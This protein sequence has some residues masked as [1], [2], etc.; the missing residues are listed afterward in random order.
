MKRDT[1]CFAVSCLRGRSADRLDPSSDTWRLLQSALLLMLVFFH[2]SPCLLPLSLTPAPIDKRFICVA[3]VSLALSIAFFFS[4]VSFFLFL[5]PRCTF[6]ACCLLLQLLLVVLQF[7]WFIF[8]RVRCLLRSL[9]CSVFPRSGTL[10][11]PQLRTRRPV[12]GRRRPDAGA[13]G[14]QSRGAGSRFR[15]WARRRRGTSGIRLDA[16]IDATV[17]F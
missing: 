12:R 14:S 5:S 11:S 8:L 16:D 9:L 13:G 17:R 10:R 15:D 1:P 2:I 7:F 6:V 4:F 3:L